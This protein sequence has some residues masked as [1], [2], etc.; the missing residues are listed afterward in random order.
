MRPLV[1]NTLATANAARDALRRAADQ[2]EQRLGDAD[3]LVFPCDFVIDLVLFLRNTADNCDWISRETADA[4][5]E[6]VEFE[7]AYE[8]WLAANPDRAAVLKE[9][10]P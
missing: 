1:S 7:G 8:R 5:A 4:H 6:E 3:E 10:Q 9:L 2:F